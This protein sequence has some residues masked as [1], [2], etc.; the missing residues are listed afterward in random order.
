MIDIHCH[1]LPGMDDGPATWDDA[2]EM[3]RVAV[4]DGIEEIVATP[5]MTP[6]LY[7]NGPGEVRKMVD[8]SN[9]RI[10]ELGLP[11]VI[12]PGGDVR[13]TADLPQC[14]DADRVPVLGGKS[15]DRRYLVCEL[16]AP[17]V[18]PNSQSVFFE[19]QLRGITPIITHPERNVELQTNLDL[20]Y[21]FVCDGAL[22]QVTAESLTGGFG[23]EAAVAARKML[24]CNLV[25][26]I[27]SDAHSPLHRR[28]IL[29]GGVTAAAKVVGAARAHEMVTT[30]P[31]ALIAGSPVQVPEP[32]EPRTRTPFVSALIS[33]FHP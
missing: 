5:H 32:Q 9:E 4:A 29:S 21:R 19:L 18:P 23:P 30:L 26:V 25:H 22:A 8:E 31:A 11:L 10:R 14:V 33:W 2:I 17:M 13:F 15:G 28:P 27:A 24:A 1:I 16:P 7:Q 12:H 3:C 6:G 20:L